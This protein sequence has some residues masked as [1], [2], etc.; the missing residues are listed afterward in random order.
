MKLLLDVTARV[1]RDHFWF[2]GLRRFVR[3]LL[4]QAQAGRPQMD[5]LD[6]GCG[7]GTN[8][9]VLS[10]YGRAC[11]VDREL[12][13]V[14]RASAAGR[15]VGQ[16]TVTKLPFFGQRFDLVTSFDVL[17]CLD[18]QDER[19]AVAEMFR[20]LRPGGRVIINV[21]AM[22]ALTGN[23]SVLCREVRRYTAPT[24][25]VLLEGAGFLVE[26]LTYTNTTMLPILVPLRLAQR[27]VGLTSGEEAGHEMQV[28]PWPLNT[29]LDCM[30][31]VEA[32]VVRR[33]D[34]P[35]GSSLLAMARKPAVS[36]A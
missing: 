35:C 17:Y 32:A 14:R 24:L 8:L 20:V 2:R 33:V 1:E 26:R 21:A 10:D 22:P 23:H 12:A 13:G 30:L 6:C 36:A 15:T 18:G 29:A 28:P 16:A 34:L 31:M 5:I 25:R 19:A 3:P 9:H 4:E 11:G 27:A 7:T